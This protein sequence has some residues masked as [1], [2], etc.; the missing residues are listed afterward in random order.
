MIEVERD[1]ELIAL[2]WFH[3]LHGSVI[4]C[5]AVAHPDSRGRWL[6]RDLF[7]LIKDTIINETDCSACVSQIHYPAIAR[8]WGKLGFDVYP[9]FAILKVKDVD[10]GRTIRIATDADSRSPDQG[11]G[12]A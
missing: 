9:T 12:E 8:M 10:D 3:T 7:A 1:G 2:V 5:H 4:E 11:S 6:T